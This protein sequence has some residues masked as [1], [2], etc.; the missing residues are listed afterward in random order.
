MV[1]ISSHTLKHGIAD[2][3][4][5]LETSNANASPNLSSLINHINSNGGS[6]TAAQFAQKFQNM[7]LPQSIKAMGANTVFNKLDQNKDGSI[8][9]LDVSAGVKKLTHLHINNSDST[10]NA[11]GGQSFANVLASVQQGLEQQSN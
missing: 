7:D 2:K 5:S 1:A 11:L 10:S 4:V 6:I 8:S 3:L 9:A